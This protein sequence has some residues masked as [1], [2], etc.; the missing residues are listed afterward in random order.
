M[1][2][3]RITQLKFTFHFCFLFIDTKLFF[4]FSFICNDKITRNS[5]NNP[6]PVVFGELILSFNSCELFKSET[7]CFFLNLIKI[8][9]FFSLLYLSCNL[10]LFRPGFSYLLKI[11]RWV[12]RDPLMISGTIKASQMKLCTVIVP[13]KAYQNKKRNFQKYDI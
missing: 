2:Y 12:S 3:G 1:S 7:R 10:T 5:S 8:C 11:Q 9:K 6:C 13:L 4:Y